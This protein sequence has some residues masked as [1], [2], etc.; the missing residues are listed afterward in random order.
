MG[1]FSFVERARVTCS[2]VS[3]HG[4]RWTAL[5]A[6]SATGIVVVLHFQCDVDRHS[7]LFG[8]QLGSSVWD[9]VHQRLRGEGSVGFIVYVDNL[10][11]PFVSVPLLSSVC[12]RGVC[13]LFIS[14]VGW[15]DR[16]FVYVD[17]LVSP[18]VSVPLLSSVCSWCLENGESRIIVCIA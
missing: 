3:F 10:V 7:R 15:C 14:T 12:S 16:I 4:V 5:F 6:S 2:A 18:F 1:S 9:W 13:V 8:V 17:N 11:S